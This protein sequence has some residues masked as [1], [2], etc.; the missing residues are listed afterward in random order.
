M[1]DFLCWLWGHDYKIVQHLTPQARKLRCRRCG[2]YFAMNDEFQA[3]LEWDADLE[4]LYCMLCEVE[5]TNL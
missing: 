3:L 4:A 2:K 1:S 5:R